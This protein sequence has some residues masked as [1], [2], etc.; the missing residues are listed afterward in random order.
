M[1]DSKQFY[2]WL[3]EHRVPFASGFAATIICLAV[4]S[5]M[6][7]WQ[8][9][10]QSDQK[11]LGQWGTLEQGVALTVEPTASRHVETS[12]AKPEAFQI[13]KIAALVASTNEGVAQLQ[14]NILASEIAHRF[15]NPNDASSPS[16]T[17][18]RPALPIDK[19][20]HLPSATGSQPQTAPVNFAEK[21]S[22]AAAPIRDAPITQKLPSSPSSGNAGI[23]PQVIF[24]THQG[25]VEPVSTHETA[26]TSNEVASD[27][28]SGPVDDAIA[29]VRLDLSREKSGRAIG[30][31]PIQFDRPARI[32]G[33]N[34]KV[35]LA[36]VP[37]GVSF[38]TGA[39]T[40]LGHWQISVAELKATQIVIDQHVPDH[41]RLTAM[42]LNGRNVVVSGSNIDIGLTAEPAETRLIGVKKPAST[43]AKAA[44][45]ANTAPDKRVETIK[46][47][48]PPLGAKALAPKPKLKAPALISVKSPAR[49]T[50]KSGGGEYQIPVEQKFKL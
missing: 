9:S 38:T 10:G 1:T 16:V 24:E 40:S 35:L 34:G 17:A 42:L 49:L 48:S 31:L 41:F 37:P 26:E 39:R 33:S 46:R 6:M 12:R 13:D 3:T 22:A 27:T 19:T 14:P 36:P 28:A 2:A 29:S 21:Y 32:S 4:L 30:W 11:P 45:G 7:S 50:E 43:K 8:I 20:D 5:P 47:A 44:N 18:T 23:M 25:S 15:A